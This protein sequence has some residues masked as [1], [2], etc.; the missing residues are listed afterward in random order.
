M[1]QLHAV[2]LLLFCG[3]AAGQVR[4]LRSGQDVDAKKKLVLGASFN[5]TTAHPSMTII[6]AVSWKDRYYVVLQETGGGEGR[7]W[8]TSEV[9]AVKANLVSR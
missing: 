6:S 3:L 2:F 1:M 9:V 5:I 7:W 8:P 4:A